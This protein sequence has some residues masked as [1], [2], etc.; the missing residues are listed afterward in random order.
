MEE[1]LTAL[2]ANV[3]G[4]GCHWVRAPQKKAL[5][6]VVMSRVSG[7]HDYTGQGSSGYVVSR[8]QLDCYATTYQDVKILSRHVKRTLSGRS[9]GII[10]AIFIDSERDLPAADAGDVKQL[11]RT[12]IDIFVHHTE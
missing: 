3:A 6:F 4:G 7:R 1:A 10:R 9:V 2:L 8:V 5:P 11:F 12:T